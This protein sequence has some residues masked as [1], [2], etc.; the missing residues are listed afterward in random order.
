MLENINVFITAVAKARIEDL[1]PEMDIERVGKALQ[2]LC[3]SLARKIERYDACIYHGIEEPI[4]DFAPLE[5]YARK[6]GILNPSEDDLR[7]IGLY[8]FGHHIT[9]ALFRDDENTLS[10]AYLVK[11]PFIRLDLREITIRLGSDFPVES[12]RNRELRCHPTAVVHRLGA[13]AVSCWIEV[14]TQLT[15]ED[16]NTLIHTLMEERVNIDVSGATTTSTLGNY[17]HG[18]AVTLLVSLIQV[19]R[20]GKSDPVEM[21]K[22]DIRRMY[23]EY[24]ENIGTAN[25]VL[26]V[27]GVSMKK[28][29]GDMTSITSVEDLVKY[30]PRQ[31]ASLVTGLKNWRNYALDAA[32]QHYRENLAAIYQDQLVMA[33]TRGVVIYLR[34]PREDDSL[35]NVNSALRDPD[36]E[37]HH[38]SVL[39]S[40]ADNV[41][42]IY[43]L[44]GIVE[45]VLDS[46]NLRIRTYPLKRARLGEI[47]KFLD[48]VERGLEEI[49]NYSLVTA[50]PVRTV[51]RM[52]LKAHG[53][54]SLREVVERRLA[55]IHRI[56]AER[57]SRRMNKLLLVLTFYLAALGVSNIVQI[58]QTP[59]DTGFWLAFLMAISIIAVATIIAW[60]LFDLISS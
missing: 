20:E 12:L 44:V 42:Q 30:C 38:H 55:Y 40:F 37:R 32:V 27:A 24:V 52:A 26:H 3:E 5:E 54:L 33:G 10:M 48:L 14:P 18:L 22:E 57:A 29:G 58:I 34:E 50:D 16:T 23:M 1:E 59:L 15:V 6:H 56:L 25:I 17:L 13:A 35:N 39:Q 21:L 31:V 28:E 19:L 41:L 49:D 60:K 7:Y 47:E 43:Q 45:T 11:T 4:V 53:V 2:S 9:S 8:I 46:Y 36:H 51:L